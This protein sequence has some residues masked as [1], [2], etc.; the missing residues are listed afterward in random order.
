MLDP[1]E[2]AALDQQVA[3]LKELMPPVWWGLYRESI[4]QGFTPQ[5]SLRLVQTYIVSNG[6]G[7]LSIFPPDPPPNEEKDKDDEED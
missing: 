3:A 2:R 5:Q 4:M 6:A 1:K 7:N